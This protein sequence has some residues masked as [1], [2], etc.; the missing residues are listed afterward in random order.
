MPCRA[1]RTERITMSSDVKLGVPV[2]GKGVR[3]AIHIA[4]APVKAHK[5]LK[6]GARVGVERLASGEMISCD[7]N[8]IGVV[9]PFRERAIWKDEVFYLCL[10]P[11]SVTGMR[12]HWSH[13]AFYEPPAN[14]PQDAVERAKENLEAFAQLADLTLEGLIGA[15]NDYLDHN[16]YLCDGGKWESFQMSETFW[17]DFQTYTGRIVPEDDRGHFFSCSC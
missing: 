9:D 4:V 13:P 2:Y 16:E 8:H 12:H 10:F 5:Q 1:H 11:G 6:P 17:D 14:V 15:A 7:T 3:D